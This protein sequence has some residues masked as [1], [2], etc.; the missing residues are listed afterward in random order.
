M[1]FN[2]QSTIIISIFI[3]LSACGINTNGVVKTEHSNTNIDQ[4]EKLSIV[5][6]FKENE[7][8]PMNERIVLF[9]KLKK[10]SPTAY[11][12]ENEEALNFYGYQLLWNNQDKDAFLIFKMLVSEF[13]NSPNV[14]DSY[15]E[16]HLKMGDKNQALI[17]YKKSLELNPDNFNA[18]D[19]IAFIL[20]PSKT[21]ENP[22]DKFLKVYQVG[23]Y[24]K[25]LDELGKK[26]T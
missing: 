13:P 10:E 17:N 7:H 8:L 12:F 11:D 19:Q 26:I 24:Q 16:I 2:I 6:V 9:Y 15:G 14:Y 18:E 20:D 5:Q 21:P 25:D 4:N 22:A 23:E 3:S 1:K